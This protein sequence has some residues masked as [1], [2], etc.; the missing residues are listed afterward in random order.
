MAGFADVDGVKLFT[1]V[2]VWQG[3][4]TL[5][6]NVSGVSLRNPTSTTD[7]VNFDGKG[8]AETDSGFCVRGRVPT[9]CS[10]IEI[11][12]PSPICQWSGKPKESRDRGM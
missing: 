4:P 12:T 5:I 6:M 1:Q 10:L 3:F 8:S 9:T 11:Y 2:Y 7:F